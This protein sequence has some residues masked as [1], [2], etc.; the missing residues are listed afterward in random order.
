MALS[1]LQAHLA[2]LDSLSW[3]DRQ[4]ALAKNLLA[5]NVFDWGAKEAAALMQ[6][7]GFGFQQ[8]LTHLQSNIRHFFFLKYMQRFLKYSPTYQNCPCRKAL[9]SGPHGK[10]AE[11][12]AAGTA[13]LRRYL[14]R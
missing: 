5:G 11:P 10:L 7:E 3:S 8:A 9:V 4:E 1:L 6:R 14:P 12:T 13:P 2:D